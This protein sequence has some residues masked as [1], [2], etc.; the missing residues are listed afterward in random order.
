MML[1]LRDRPGF[2]G[3]PTC[4]RP[5]GSPHQFPDSPEHALA[6]ARLAYALLW[7]GDKSGY[8]AGP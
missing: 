7:H 5:S 1:A 8:S 4:A 3:V 6:T 2:A